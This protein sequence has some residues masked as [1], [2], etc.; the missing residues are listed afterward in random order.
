MPAVKPY[1]IRPIGTVGGGRFGI[2]AV[3]GMHRIPL[4][5]S[6]SID[7]AMRWIGWFIKDGQSVR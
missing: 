5:V 4:A 6:P 2:Y 1:R 3:R 7:F